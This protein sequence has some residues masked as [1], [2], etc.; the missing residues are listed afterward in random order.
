VTL[1][2]PAP[3]GGAQVALSS[4]NKGVASVPSSVT[5]P[6]GSIKASFTVNTS[7]VLFSTNVTI[8]A[9]YNGT[10]KQA[11]LA[12]NAPLGLLSGPLL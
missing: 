1:S 4:S 10:T 12:V 8:S 11:N 7:I 5:V 9:S 3:S 6:A 2:S